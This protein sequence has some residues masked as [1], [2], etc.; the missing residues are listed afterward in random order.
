MMRG[1]GM[2]RDI[3]RILTAE[4]RRRQ[5][6]LNDFSTGTRAIYVQTNKELVSRLLP[7]AWV[8]LPYFYIACPTILLSSLALEG[9]I[10]PL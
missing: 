4:G 1:T 5:N 10:K 3:H 9:L 8:P 7:P 2:T 6:N